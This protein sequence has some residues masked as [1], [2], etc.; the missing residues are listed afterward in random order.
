M[1]AQTAAT[2][3]RAR[4]HPTLDAAPVVKTIALPHGLTLPYVEQGDPEGPP[5]LFLHGY[6]DSWRSFARVL[7]HLPP[8]FRAIAL[9]QRGHGDAGRP[10]AGYHP[11]VLAADLE[12]FMDALGIEE[13]VIAGHSM[14]SVVAQRFAIE[15]PGRTRGLVLL[16][17]FAT[18]NGNPVIEDLWNSDIAT[19]TD[20]VDPEFVREFQESTLARPVSPAF[21]DM[22]VAESLKVPAHVWR[23][24]LAGQMDEDVSGALGRI[25]APTLILWG[26]HDS[27]L[28][29]RTQDALAAG[30][31]GAWLTV[32]PGAG[33]GL[34]WEEPARVAAD[35][36]AF[37]DGLAR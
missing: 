17:A 30:I 7:G 1:A 19:L 8:R 3:V 12:D 15:N 35:L 9:T 37:A 27:I 33:H 22:V 10:A 28:P 20:P 11:R 16:G 25:A 21:L 2:A 26:S 24:A 14:G 31:A 32:Y 13:A 34:H 36:T 18:L 4:A 23:A 5:V 6:T 29:R